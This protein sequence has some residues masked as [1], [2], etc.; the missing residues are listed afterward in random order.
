MSGSAATNVAAAL[1]EAEHSAMTTTVGLVVHSL[2]D[3]LA[4]GAAFGLTLDLTLILFIA[5]M[6]HKVY[7]IT[8]SIFYAIQFKINVG[9]P[10]L[11]FFGIRYSLL[12]SCVRIF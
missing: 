11:A 3:G 7:R 12:D 1:A 5:I 9:L 4:I 2:A 6:L 10:C 8:L